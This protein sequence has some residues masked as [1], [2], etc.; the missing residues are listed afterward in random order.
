V[1]VEQT[2]ELMKIV[3]AGIRSRERSGRTVQLS[4]IQTR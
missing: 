4:E 2:I 3:I 1:P